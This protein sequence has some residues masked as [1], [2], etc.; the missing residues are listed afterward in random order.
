[1]RLFLEYLAYRKY[2]I[3]ALMNSVR[4]K[5]LKDLLA[6]AR[7]IHYAMQHGAMTY[8]QAKQKTKPLLLKI[9]DSI[10]LIAKKYNK[11]PKYIRFHDLGSHL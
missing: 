2:N 4:S 11:R 9:N 1:M 5:N 3:G 6:E 8:E 7:A 10:K